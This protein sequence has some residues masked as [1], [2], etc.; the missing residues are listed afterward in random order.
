[1]TVTS[2]RIQE[3]VAQQ[4]IDLVPKITMKGY[5]FESGDLPSLSLRE[6]DSSG[7]NNVVSSELK[8]S[9]M[10]EAMMLMPP[11]ASSVSTTS[12][13]NENDSSNKKSWDELA[14]VAG[15]VLVSPSSA[16]SVVSDLSVMESPFMEVIDMLLAGKSKDEEHLFLREMV[17][18]L[19]TEV[20]HLKEDLEN[21]KRGFG[22]GII[23]NANFFARLSKTK[24]PNPVATAKKM[25]ND[26]I[27]KREQPV[28]EEEATEMVIQQ[29]TK[30]IE[31][32]NVRNS[33]YVS[34]IKNL[35]K[36]LELFKTA[37]R[38]RGKK[39]ESL[40]TELGQVKEMAEKKSKKEQEE[41]AAQKKE[42]TTKENIVVAK[43]G[44]EIFL[45]VRTILP[46]PPK[47]GDKIAAFNK[48]LTKP[49]ALS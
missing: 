23:S 18:D 31:E 34:T 35:E 19:M 39:I 43:N 47:Q 14:A 3:T 30:K 38:A 20:D 40:Q 5:P 32:Q 27:K 8:A 49:Y 7:V 15:S 48:I 12:D 46:S 25:V 37:C 13:S 9:E 24:E 45:P 33:D 28:S 21:S 17:V 36:Q 10:S 1:V 44:V 2:F 41:K 6:N 29:L 42:Q 26:M 4:T 16:S 11:V 22:A